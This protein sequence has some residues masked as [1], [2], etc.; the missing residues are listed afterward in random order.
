MQLCAEIVLTPETIMKLN[1]K[2]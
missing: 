1:I 2:Q